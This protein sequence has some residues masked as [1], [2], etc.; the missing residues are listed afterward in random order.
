MLTV[1]QL[2]SIENPGAA[3]PLRASNLRTNFKAKPL[4][5]RTAID[6]IQ[7]TQA[8]FFVNIRDVTLITGGIVDKNGNTLGPASTLQ[9]VQARWPVTASSQSTLTALSS[10]LGKNGSITWLSKDRQTIGV[11]GTVASFANVPAQAVPYDLDTGI[12]IASGGLVAAGQVLMS[13]AVVPE[14]LSI[15]LLL[16][17]AFLA[18]VGV[19]GLLN[20][21]WWEAT[22][23]APTP[24]PPSTGGTT[25]DA[26]DSTQDDGV[27]PANIYGSPPTD[28]DTTATAIA[29]A[30]FPSIDIPDLPF[31]AGWS[32]G[33]GPNG[34]ILPGGPGIGLQDPNGG[35]G[36]GFG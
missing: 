20:L 23:N 35:D 29:E 15:P 5:L 34:G 16:T 30:G 33:D 19:G 18:G 25:S 11:V 13:I 21:G 10:A 6:Q 3:P 31:L 12:A 9:E 27:D 1:K 26:G 14:P 17:G 24:A 28:S 36:D 22:D 2:V 4:S 7:G 8:Y 32:E